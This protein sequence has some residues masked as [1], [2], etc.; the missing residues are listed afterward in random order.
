MLSSRHSL[1]NHK[2]TKMSN[3]VNVTKCNLDLGRVTRTD[4]AD[5]MSPSGRL[6]RRL[7]RTER[8]W[9]E[10]SVLEDIWSFF[11][12]DQTPRANGRTGD[13][14][15]GATIG[16]KIVSPNCSAIRK[17]RRGRLCLFANRCV[18][19]TVD[20]QRASMYNCE[21]LQPLALEKPRQ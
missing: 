18:S 12:K 10:G 16:S 19:P 1:A 11:P 15:V 13:R 6:L 3:V 20:G 17:Q 2:Y 4:T 5:T 14:Q 9:M 21:E 8:R 7:F